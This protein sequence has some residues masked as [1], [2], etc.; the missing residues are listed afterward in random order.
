VA[1]RGVT[2]SIFAILFLLLAIS[3]FSKPFSRDPATAFIFLGWRTQGPTQVI[4]AWLFALY[5]LLYAAGIWQMRR[6]VLD[7][8]YC[9]AA[10]VLLNM[11][12]FGLRNTPTPLLLNIVAMVI[13]IGVSSG[14][15]ILLTRRKAMLS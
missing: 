3:N 13:G 7:L 5:L 10:W 2:L 8:A 1:K 4:L 11:L 14:A 6:W 15:A 9:Y 12:L